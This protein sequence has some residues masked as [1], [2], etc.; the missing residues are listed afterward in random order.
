M[1]RPPITSRPACQQ[2]VALL[3]MMFIIGLAVTAYVVK[4]YDAAA[5]KAR[6]EE[7]TI[8]ALAEAK[9]ALIA[10][11]VAHPRW[12]GTMPFPDRGTDGGGYDG[13]SDCVAPPALDYPHLIGKLPSY[14]ESGCFESTYHT[15]IH[16]TDSSAERLWYAVSMN[17][18]R[19]GSKVPVINPGMLGNTYEWMK[20]FDHDGQLVSDRVAV[21][22]IAPGFP[23][24]IQGTIQ[25]RSKVAIENFL[26]TAT[27]QDGRTVSNTDYT[28]INEDFVM[29]AIDGSEINDR[30]IY[31]TI[32]ELIGALEK[33]VVREVKDLNFTKN[34]VRCTLLDG[35]RFQA[36]FT[37]N[38]EGVYVST[39]IDDT[40]ISRYHK[41]KDLPVN[42]F[43]SYVNT[44]NSVM[45]CEAQLPD[46]NGIVLK[47]D[48]P[49]SLYPF[50]ISNFSLIGEGIIN[51]FKDGGIKGTVK[52]AS[53]STFTVSNTQEMTSSVV[54]WPV[55]MA[56]YFNNKWYE[57]IYVVSED[58]DEITNEG[59]CLSSCLILN[60]RNREIQNI[61]QLIF[62]RNSFLIEGFAE[63]T[64]TNSVLSNYFYDDGKGNGAVAWKKQ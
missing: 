30:L 54:G 8:K 6:Q 48:S 15:N 10:W 14:S 24:T 25:D 58:F 31:I 1:M 3:L 26:E 16:T 17:L 52:P 11:S 9:E 13:K 62:S 28:R 37:W 43:Y 21:V 56:W 19:S 51:V 12:P 34:M 60:S 18:I 23:I 2:G 35:C 47:M 59:K 29:G 63:A 46:P 50:S 39:P 27:F 4:S 44:S 57:Y 53:N 61:K 49:M 5:M 38:N 40:S 45:K 20:V 41:V 33:R 55:E 42:C 22:I 32:D 7:K 36:I 64:A